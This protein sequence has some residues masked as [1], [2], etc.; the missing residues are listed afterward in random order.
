MVVGTYT[1][2]GSVL[3]VEEGAQVAQ[4]P[5]IHRDLTSNNILLGQDGRARIA[6]FGLARALHLPPASTAEQTSNIVTGT[7]GYVAPEA[8]SK[9]GSVRRISNIPHTLGGNGGQVTVHWM[10]RHSRYCSLVC[11]LS[12]SGCTL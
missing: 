9:G 8:L 12:L 4:P 11:T 10:F 2:R 3:R 6:D 5:L 7:F 1:Y